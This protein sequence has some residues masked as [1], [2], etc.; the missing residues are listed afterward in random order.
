MENNVMYKNEIFFMTEE[1]S[2]EGGEFSS[3]F[4]KDIYTNSE[5]DKIYVISRIEPFTPGD[6]KNREYYEHY[7]E[8]IINSEIETYFDENQLV[9]MKSFEKEYEKL[10]RKK[11]KYDIKNIDLLDNYSPDIGNK[12]TVIEYGSNDERKSYRNFIIKNVI[13]IE[14][15][16]EK[17]YVISYDV[18]GEKNY[19]EENPFYV[20]NVKN[21]ILSFGFYNNCEVHI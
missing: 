21:F 16:K 9:T 3:W 14:D 19:T 17:V 12:F 13:Y 7:D 6:S 4:V 5:N 10:Y 11:M 20:K 18:N 15:T 2:K 1:T 8:R